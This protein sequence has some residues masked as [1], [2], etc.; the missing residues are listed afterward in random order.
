MIFQNLMTAGGTLIIQLMFCRTLQY[1]RWLAGSVPANT[2]DFVL[3]AS[4]TD[5]PLLL[6]KMINERLESRRNKSFRRTNNNKT[7]TGLFESGYSTCF[8]NH[9]PSPC[10]YN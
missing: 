6:A 5:P 2:K 1:K 8:R 10:R 7:G 4:I 9:F 3:K